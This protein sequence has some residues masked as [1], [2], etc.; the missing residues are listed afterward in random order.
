VAP[1]GAVLERW[2]RSTEDEIPARAE[3]MASV[4]SESFDVP[5]AR[6]GN[7]VREI[8]LTL[9]RPDFHAYVV[10]VDG[11]TVAT[12]QRY[13]F[14][15]ASYL[16]S[17]GTLRSWRGLGLATHITNALAADS[18]AEGADLV[19]LGVWA[20]NAPA[21]RLYRKLGFAVLGGLSAD[22]LK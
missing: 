9:G 16:S 20:E 15:G 3:A 13:T 6:H 4:V 10:A 22:M 8:S 14:D 5:E 18:L 17:I 2:H 7:L 12:G 11:K 1:E 21:I 19:Y